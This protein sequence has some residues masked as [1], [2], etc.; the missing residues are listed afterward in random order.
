MAT[1]YA[2]NRTL[3]NTGTVNTIDP[4]DQG[5]KVKWVYDEYEASALA[6]G[7]VIELF[8]IDLPVGARIVD[9]IIDADA[10]STVTLSFGT[11]ADADEFLALKATANTADK[12][13]YTDDGVAASLGFEIEEGDGQTLII[14]T[15]GPSAA[16]GTIKV[17]VA[18]VAKG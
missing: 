17:A 6:E 9:W 15:S 10:L 3:K 13:N 2:V 7:S 16:T 14:T 5:A 12:F 11:S 18:Y 8:G 1:V 4:E